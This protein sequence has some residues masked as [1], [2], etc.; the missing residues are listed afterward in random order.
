MIKEGFLLLEKVSGIFKIRV[1]F[2]PEISAL[3]VRF[4]FD[5]GRM[6][7][8]KYLSAPPPPG[9]VLWIAVG[10]LNFYI[11]VSTI[12]H[13]CDTCIREDEGKISLQAN[14][15]DGHA[16]GLCCDSRKLIGSLCQENEPSNESLVEIYWLSFC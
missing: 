1:L 12:S 3:G 7:P 5:N 9:M 10:P 6:Y 16:S 2:W 13:K 4:N 11:N 15:Y 8:P 14:D